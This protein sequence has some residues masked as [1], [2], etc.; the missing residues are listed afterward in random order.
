MQ[1]LSLKPRESVD[2]YRLFNENIDRENIYNIALQLQKITHSEENPALLPRNK[3]YFLEQINSWRCVVFLDHENNVIASWIA[4]ELWKWIVE[5]WT[6]Y[7]H[8]DYRWMW[9][10]KKIIEALK[11]KVW[12]EVWVMS[13][14]PNKPWNAWMIVDAVKSWL[15][16]VSFD[17]L[18]QINPEAYKECCCCESF[19]N[20]SCSLSDNE[21][22]LLVDWIWERLFDNF[23]AYM[24]WNWLESI[25]DERLLKKVLQ[26]ILASSKK[27]LDEKV[28]QIKNI[29][30][31]KAQSLWITL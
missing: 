8:R 6:I 3:D 21:C 30:L 23:R 17:F 9:F 26:E 11:N 1:S 4:L 29:L 20:W 7:V 10:W 19:I 28:L 18:R 14:K 16:P 15:L 12:Y 25:Q 24:R 22:I 5:L 31:S 2:S 13:V 27:Y